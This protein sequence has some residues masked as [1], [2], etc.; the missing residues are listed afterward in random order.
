MSIGGSVLSTRVV[1]ATQRNGG[2]VLPPCLSLW[3]R[4]PSAARTERA[5]VDGCNGRYHSKNAPRPSQ[6]R[7][8]R[9]SSPRG[10]AKGAFSVCFTSAPVVSTMFNAAPR[11][12]HRLRAV[13]LP[14]WGRLFRAFLHRSI[15]C[16]LSTKNNCQFFTGGAK[17]AVFRSVLNTALFFYFF[18]FTY[19]VPKIR[20]PASP[21]PGTM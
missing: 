12:I 8:R 2:A 1:S 13:P 21:R 18:C 10:R 11:L 7:L 16:Q 14:R 4:W 3:E 17:G 15:N 20:S 9:A 19:L 5:N 6:S